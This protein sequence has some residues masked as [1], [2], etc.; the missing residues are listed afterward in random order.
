MSAEAR[1]SG[2]AA[3]SAAPTLT[4]APATDAPNLAAATAVVL[5]DPTLSEDEK[6]NVARQS[7]ENVRPDTAM[8]GFS[9]GLSVRGYMQMRRCVHRR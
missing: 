4:S 6:G 5:G 3:N 7:W 1:E 8:D 2:P 9:I